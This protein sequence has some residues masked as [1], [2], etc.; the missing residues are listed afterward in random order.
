M[1]HIVMAYIVMAVLELPASSAAS[2]ASCI[3]MAHIVMAYIVMAVPE[4][5][6]S[7]AA[8]ATERCPNAG[9]DSEPAGGCV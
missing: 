4:L 8:S 2:A 3:V 5:P 7:S 9:A 1:A 6:A